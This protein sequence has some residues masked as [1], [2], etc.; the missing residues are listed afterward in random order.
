MESVLS[1]LRLL[2]EESHITDISS[3]DD[4]LV[5]KVTETLQ[6]AIVLAKA[7]PDP[8]SIPETLLLLARDAADPDLAIMALYTLESFLY[9]PALHSL[10]SERFLAALVSRCQSATSHKLKR[11]LAQLIS[12]LSPQVA[13]AVEESGAIEFVVGLLS[14]RD[15]EKL[16]EA[17]VLAVYALAQ[18]EAFVPLVLEHNVVGNVLV[19]L[20][21]M[22]S[23]SVF[24]QNVLAVLV[25]LSG[26][27]LGS[28]VMIE[29][30]AADELLQVLRECPVNQWKN[31]A[32]LMFGNMGQTETLACKILNLKGFKEEFT[33]ILAFESGDCELTSSALN[34][35]R[36]LALFAPSDS[37]AFTDG[38]MILLLQLIETGH[39]AVSKEKN[40]ISLNLLLNSVVCS[41]TLLKR[42][43]NFADLIHQ[44][45]VT[46]L[47]VKL[48]SK[49]SEEAIKYEIART[50]CVFACQKALSHEVVTNGGLGFVTEMIESKFEVLQNEGMEALNSL[51]Q[52]EPVELCSDPKFLRTLRLLLHPENTEAKILMGLQC[53]DM[54]LKV[55]SGKPASTLLKSL[56][57]STSGDS[58]IEPFA[59]HSNAGISACVASIKS[60]AKK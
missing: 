57:G 6:Q 2:Q 36:N 5:A 29:Q 11:Q 50:I 20:E 16:V 32:L 8:G 38:F 27:V 24:K 49:Y 3:L 31:M 37:F 23:F 51:C 19:I 59:L 22:S 53:A 35:L 46:Q 42:K 41:R 21:D 17:G 48:R 28:E 7:K 33:K 30:G 56:S 34:T 15:Q 44:K 9:D 1:S 13:A 4:E 43:P 26:T 54:V 18:H 25:V 55:A 14:C 60:K 58:L 52:H 47:L 10:V 39:K 12:L 40:S 45:E